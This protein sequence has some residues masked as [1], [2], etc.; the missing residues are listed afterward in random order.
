[1]QGYVEN[2][3]GLFLQQLLLNILDRKFCQRIKSV[4]GDRSDM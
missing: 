1:M 3:L 4:V 2:P